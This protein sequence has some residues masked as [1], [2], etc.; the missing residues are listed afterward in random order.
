MDSV[1]QSGRRGRMWPMRFVCRALLAA[2]LITAFTAGPARADG[3]PASDVLITDPIYFPYQ[4]AS[5]GQAAKL[6]R[7][8]TAAK[9]AGQTVRVAVIQSP[10]DLG[11]V[12]NLY[13]HP[14]EYTN[15]LATEVQN[16]VEPG[17]RGNREELLVVMPA[18]Y[19]TKNVPEKVARMLRGVELPSNADSDTLVAAAG[20]GVQE[21][22]R[23]NGR[24]IRAE[25]DKPA[26][27]SGGGGALTI[28]LV[29]V[30]LLALV[31]LLIVVRVR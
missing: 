17:A 3:D 4:P 25:F 9:G 12:A 2:L 10:Q 8:V 26:G 16:P 22:A 7:V 27:D 11:A 19:G 28:V 31:A 23:A 20:W 5:A 18:G 29:V 21:L 6:R 30:A 1:G 24:P 14:Q 13:G 15:L